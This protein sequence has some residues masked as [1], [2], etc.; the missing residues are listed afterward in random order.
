[1]LA[2]NIQKRCYCIT[3]TKTF[4][5]IVVVLF[6]ITFIARAIHARETKPI[7]IILD[8]VPGGMPGVARYVLEKLTIPIVFL[9]V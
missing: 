8:A 9:D 4:K 2:I 5:R 1:M 3:N 7:N 6:F